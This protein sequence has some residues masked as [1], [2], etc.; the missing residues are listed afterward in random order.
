MSP[1]QVNEYNRNRV[2]QFPPYK[3]ETG[4]LYN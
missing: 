3:D 4:L 2:T 1:E